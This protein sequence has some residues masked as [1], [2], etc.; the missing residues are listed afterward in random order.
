MFIFLVS[1][2]DY[3]EPELATC[4]RCGMFLSVIQGQMFLEVKTAIINEVTSRNVA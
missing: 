3:R 1:D 4:L 2:K